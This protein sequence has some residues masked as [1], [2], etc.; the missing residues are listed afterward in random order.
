[1]LLILLIFHIFVYSAPWNQF[2]QELVPAFGKKVPFVSHQADQVMTSAAEHLP[3]DLLNEIYFDVL[4]SRQKIDSGDIFTLIA[5]NRYLAR[6]FVQTNS[7]QINQLWEDI[8]IKAFKSH[9]S[10]F[11]MMLE[12]E[13]LGT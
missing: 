5:R 8:M 1:M 13:N 4:I 7:P 12:S 6:K 11:Q 10:L 2:V 9:S 3:Q